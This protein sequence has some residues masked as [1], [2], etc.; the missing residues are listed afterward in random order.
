MSV[1]QEGRQM[2]RGPKNPKPNQLYRELPD[3][4]EPALWLPVK[5]AA[6]RE[7]VRTTPIPIS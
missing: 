5:Y 6:W 1:K 2:A 4:S 7:P 3:L